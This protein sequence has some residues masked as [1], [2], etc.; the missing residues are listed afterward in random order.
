MKVISTNKCL[1]CGQEFEY[2]P[3]INTAR[4]CSKECWEIWLYSPEIQEHM[5]RDPD[6]FHKMYG[7]KTVEFELTIKPQPY[8]VGTD[9]AG[10]PFKL[11]FEEAKNE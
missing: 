9:K 1:T 5:R 11:E 6:G 10:I 3:D 2:N 8:L 7:L 4:S